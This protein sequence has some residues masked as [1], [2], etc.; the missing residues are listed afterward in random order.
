MLGANLKEGNKYF[1][2]CY[3]FNKLL[4][5]Q[6]GVSIENKLFNVYE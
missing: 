4:K 2:Y 5:D 6:E 1:D 3:N